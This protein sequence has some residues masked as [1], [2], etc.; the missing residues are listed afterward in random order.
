MNKTMFFTMTALVAF[1]AMAAT[2]EPTSIEEQEAK[3]EAFRAKI[4]ARTGGMISRPHTAGAKFVFVNAQKLVKTEE[5]SAPVATMT[6]ILRHD[7]CLEAPVKEEPFSLSNAQSLMKAQQAKG[8]I[9]LVED[10]VM[11]TVLV[12]PEAAWGVINVRKLN[13]DKPNPLLL[14]QRTRRE[15]WRVFAMVN[16]GGSNTK[17]GKCVM[18]TVLSL[19]DID[20]LGAEAFCPEPVNAVVAHLNKLGI[21]EY[22]TTTY[23]KACEEGWAPAPTNDVQKAIWEKVHAM[24]T[25]PIKIKPETKKVKE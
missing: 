21:K 8:A 13:A 18:Q 2:K 23:R 3:R 10:D 5:I 11:P 1:G 25:E 6:R 4:A 16:G 20:A 9:F 14:A 12:A 22:Q 24:P 15:M 19:G 7:I 17:M